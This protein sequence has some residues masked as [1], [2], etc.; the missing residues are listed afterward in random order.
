[1]QGADISEVAPNGRVHTPSQSYFKELH[2]LNGK[3]AFGAQS[4]LSDMPETHSKTV[5]NCFFFCTLWF[6]FNHFHDHFC[7]LISKKAI[8]P[9]YFIMHC[10]F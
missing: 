1:M 4:W 10:I 5:N 8:A 6:I 2:I 3:K 7:A 9:R